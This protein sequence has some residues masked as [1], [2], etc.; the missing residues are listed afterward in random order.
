MKEDLY[1]LADNGPWRNDACMGYSLKAMRDAGIDEEL[2]KKAMRCLDRSFDD[3]SVE[4]AAQ[5]WKKSGAE[6]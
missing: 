6:L 1:A 2:I 3:V 5:F 4:E